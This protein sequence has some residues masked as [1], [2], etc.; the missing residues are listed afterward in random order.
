MAVFVRYPTARHRLRCTAD[1]GIEGCSRWI[2]PGT[3]YADEVCTPFHEGITGE[4]WWRFRLCPACAAYYRHTFPDGPA[5][6]R[7][8]RRSA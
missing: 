2:E 6:R 4:G 1:A 7:T 3:R 8:L 5:P